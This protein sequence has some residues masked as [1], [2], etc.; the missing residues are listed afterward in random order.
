MNLKKLFSGP[1][2]AIVF[3]LAVGT[4]IV[5]LPA[6]TGTNSDD[7]G[8]ST[9]EKVALAQCLTENGTVFYGAFWCPHCANQKAAFGTEAMEEIDY[10]ECSNPDRSMTAA[11][12]SAGIQSYPTWEFA[13]GSRQT[14]EVPLIELAQAAGCAYGE[15]TPDAGPETPAEEDT[16]EAS[17]MKSQETP[18]EATDAEAEGASDEE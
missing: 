18:E 14:G 3:G 8:R 1:G 6:L 2:L 7:G 17:D 16:S 11:C 10:V 5:M 13:D 12:Q 15:Y 9:E 4:L